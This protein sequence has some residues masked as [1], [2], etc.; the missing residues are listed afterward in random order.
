MKRARKL[1]RKV[2]FTSLEAEIR[3]TRMLAYLEKTR[4]GFKSSIEGARKLSKDAWR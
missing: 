2:F 4:E 1:P 3:R